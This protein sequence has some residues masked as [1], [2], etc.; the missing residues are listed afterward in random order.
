VRR[1][2]CVV[3]GGRADYGLLYW[4]MKEIAAADDLELQVVATGM[5]LSPDFGDTLQ[6]IE[7]DGFSVSARVEMLLSS[8]TAVGVAKSIGLGVIGFADA[9]AR[10]APDLLLV[11]GDRFEILAAVEAALVARLPVAH[12]CGGDITEGAYDDA[13]RHAITKMA[14]LH[15][16]TN[17]AAAR[18]LRQMGE[19]PRRVFTVGSPGIDNIQRQRPMSREDVARETGLDLSRPTLLV[20][21]HPATLGDEAASVEL[22]ELL[23]ALDL[24]GCGMTIAITLPNADND[25]R[26]LRRAFEAF[27]TARSH[28]KTFAVLGSRLYLNLM[29]HADAIVGNSSSGLYE[30]PSLGTPTVDIGDRQKGRLKASSVVSCGSERGAIADAIRTVLTRSKVPT[31]NP[32]GTGEASRRIVEILRGVTDFRPLTRKRFVDLAG[33]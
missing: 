28:V 26:A 8:D 27:A 30:A 12:L 18:R 31:D 21:Y 5:H 33:V 11:L 23:A 14:H 32:Y 29:R 17:E 24:V 9:F 1:K 15:F 3:T 4:P 20:T 13:I 7:E 2:I 25:G 16:A 6:R 10:L 22:A 19:D